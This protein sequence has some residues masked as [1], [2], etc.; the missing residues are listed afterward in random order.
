MPLASRLASEMNC[1]VGVMAL[2]GY[3]DR[4]EKPW[5]S[6]PAEG[7][8]FNEWANAVRDAV[9]ALKGYS[10]S[11]S[12][13]K[14]LTG[15]FHDWG[16]VAG[17]MHTNQALESESDKDTTA[18][19]QMVLF[20]V[21]L[22]A[23][24]ETPGIESVVVP[25][26]SFFRRIYDTVTT[27]SYRILF[28]NVY[29]TQ[30]FV[31]KHLARLKMGLGLTSLRAL[32]L[33]P[34]RPVDEPA[35]KEYP[36]DPNRLMYMTYPYFGLFR[37]IVFGKMHRDF[38]GAHPPIN[39]RKTPVLYMYGLDKNIMFHPDSSVALLQQENKNG[40]KSNAIAI[41]DAGHWLYLQ[42]ADQCFGEIKRFMS[43]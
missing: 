1:L 3:D 16:V 12:T 20:D 39:L 11:K 6:H 9:K 14:K 37:S 42:K 2:P 17:L 29:F 27:L 13:P 28:A 38:R 10:I 23:H 8:T 30:R 25:R 33:I 35:W 5:T 26:K 21:L 15:I 40:N 36:V 43:S 32:G 22:D 24:P 41:E 7:Y 18:V 31:S 19:D 34:S 4:P